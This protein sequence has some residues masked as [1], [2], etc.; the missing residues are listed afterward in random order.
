MNLTGYFS[1]SIGSSV[2][3]YRFSPIIAPDASAHINYHGRQNH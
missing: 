2:T 1:N 3:N